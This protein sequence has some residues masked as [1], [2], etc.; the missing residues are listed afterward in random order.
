[1]RK[2]NKVLIAFLI[3]LLISSLPLSMSSFVYAEDTIDPPGV[4]LDGADE[5]NNIRSGSN[6]SSGSSEPSFGGGGTPGAPSWSDINGNP[7]S[8]SGG[9][10]QRG[11]HDSEV[12]VGPGG[13]P[14]YGGGNGL[15]PGGY[16][17]YDGG[18]GLGSGGYLGYDGGNGLGSGGY[19]GFDGGN[20]L[21]PGGLYSFWPQNTLNNNY[22][23]TMNPMVNSHLQQQMFGFNHG[24]LLRA[25]A[26]SSG[27]GSVTATN[28]H[29][30]N[31]FLFA[32]SGEHSI[33][34]DSFVGAAGDRVGAF[35]SLVDLSRELGH[36]QMNTLSGSSYAGNTLVFALSVAAPGISYLNHTG[37]SATI[38]SI[39]FG[40]TILDATKNWKD[41]RA[42]SVTSSTVTQAAQ[43][44]TPLISSGLQTVLTRT[45]VGLG[46]IGTGLSAWESVT[47][48]SE[49]NYLDGTGSILDGIG[50]AAFTVSLA[51]GGVTPVGLAAA[52]VGVVATGAGLIIR[53]RKPIGKALKWAW[54]G[55]A[56]AGRWIG[57]RVADGWNAA[58]NLGTNIANAASE[59]GRNIIDGASRVGNAISDSAGNVGNAISDGASNV[60]NS[61][62][63]GASNVGNAISM[64][65]VMSVMRSVRA[66]E[67]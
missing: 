3:T 30:F 33:G 50:S 10:G 28:S 18:N 46:I 57:N 66:Q 17:G 8:G 24:N 21:D 59:A 63:E 53:Y 54:N 32:S 27:L 11:T 7:R 58:V 49:G 4:G 5:K 51:S 2:C 15:G 45:G 42:A 47:H 56:S 31:N 26:A 22:Y 64:V 39:G 1:M 13:Y 36:G 65:Q 25:T 35:Q 20:G 40:T 12:G 67:V 14:G 52:A 61:I 43:T 41:F 55:I 37:V 60:R 44:S 48:F 19:L 6:S 9:D 29:P 34:L 16:P 23:P 62:S 38:D